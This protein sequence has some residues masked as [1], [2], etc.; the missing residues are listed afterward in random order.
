MDGNVMTML[1]KEANSMKTVQT[2]C[3]P[4]L[5]PELGHFQM[6]E[7]LFV[8]EGP[9]T[10]LFPALLA[11]DCARSAQEV[12]R[13]VSQGGGGFLDAQPVDAGRNA[14]MLRRIAR[15]SGAKIVC[16]TGYHLPHFY[17]EEHWIHSKDEE[18]L[19][20][21]FRDELQNGCVECREVRPGAVKAAL[22]REGL[23][24]RAEV[25]LRAAALA[26]AEADVPIVI[27]TEKGVGGVEAVQLCRET[28]LSPA[29]ILICHIDRQA[30][31]FAPHDAIAATGAM[32][33]YDTIGRFKYHDDASEIR[34]IQHMIEG[35]HL[36]QL[37]L[38]LDTTNQRLSTY[39]GEIG[40]DY[41]LNSFLPA[42]R[43]A[44]ISEEQI[45]TMT[46]E[47]PRRAF[48]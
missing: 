39:G 9:G 48:A 16:V 13:Y 33:E 24:A 32:L 30:D 28:G 34:L 38:S 15:A 41:I 31:D 29:R 44:G 45:R 42:L 11:D 37:L 46:I 27:H 17:P 8:A 2:V 6:H 19:F 3:G 14:A 47:N 23:D 21:R 43:D 1:A 22:G 36:A 4:A 18:A 26:A 5:P 12:A 35:G 40:L 25:K 7:H 10:Q 20:A